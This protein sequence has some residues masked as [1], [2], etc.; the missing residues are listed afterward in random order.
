MSL[1]LRRRDGLFHIFPMHSSTTRDKLRINGD[2]ETAAQNHLRFL[3][4]K[5]KSFK[6][7]TSIFFSSGVL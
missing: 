2:A 4:K 3:K 5:E 7:A 1:H 6:I